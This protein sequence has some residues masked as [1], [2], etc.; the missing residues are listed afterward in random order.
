MSKDL[1]TST[2]SS[3]TS[4][5]NRYFAFCSK[6]L[7]N[8]PLPINEDVLM[9]FVSSLAHENK[10]LGTMNLYVTAVKYISRMLY[11]QY[12]DQY[13]K[14]HRLQALLSG[15][16]KSNT[17]PSKTK[18]AITTRHLSMIKLVLDMSVYD[19][20]VHWALLCVGV[21]GMLRISEMIGGAATK[22]RALTW[23]QVKFISSR[24]ITITLKASKT[25]PSKSGISI[26]IYGNDSDTCAVRALKAIVPTSSSAT[27]DSN[28]LVFRFENKGVPTRQIV[29]FKIQQLIGI[30]NLKYALGLNPKD[31]ATHSLRRGGATSLAEARVPD[32]TIKIMGRWSSE[33][34]HKYTTISTAMIQQAHQDIGNASPTHTT[35]SLNSQG[36]A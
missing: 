23:N 27:Y 18:L 17:K 26:S 14:Y 3:Y 7:I 19:N 24:H 20:K 22:D 2:H 16:N 28:S 12:A 1:A 6:Q 29:S 32:S 21:Y 10:A 30:I 36:T 8:T 9:A 5:I 11:P 15:V 13:D 33:C 31:F 35:T 4:G 34:Y 25:D